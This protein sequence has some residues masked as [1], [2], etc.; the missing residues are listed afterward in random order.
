M[1]ADQFAL[2]YLLY[3]VLPLWVLV[4]ALDWLCHRASHIE[5]TSGPK[6]SLIHLLLLAEAGAALLLGI[7]LEIDALV[8]LLMAGCFLAHEVTNYWDLSWA[9]PRREVTAAEQRVHDYLAV[10]PFLAL[11]LVMVLHWDQALAL[12]GAGLEPA[13]YILELKATPLPTGYIAGLL[14]A[15]L[16]FD[17]LP[18]LEELWRGWRRVRAARLAGGNPAG[19]DADRAIPGA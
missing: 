5:R 14:G 2:D 1:S 18:Y 16:L 3:L 11:S 17:I 13:R 6:E 9:L 4:G 10:I 12:I 19:I 8:I 15:V 7:F